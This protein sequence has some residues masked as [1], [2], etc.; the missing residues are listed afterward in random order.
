MSHFRTHLLFISLVVLW[1][2]GG[3]FGPKL[4]GLAN[5][6]SHQE[7]DEIQNSPPN[8]E[9]SQLPSQQPPEFP[10][11]STPEEEVDPALSCAQTLSVGANISSAIS[12]AANG[13]VICLS[14]GNYGPIQLANINRSGFVTITSE[15]S[16]LAEMSPDIYNS[17]YIKFVRLKLSNA[18]IRA[19]SVS[20]HFI[21]NTF[22]PETPH[23]LFNN[24]VT[25]PPETKMDYLVD[26]NSFDRGQNILF[27]GRLSLRGVDGAVISNNLFSNVPTKN[28][29]DG[30]Q[31]I[32]GSRNLMIGP[33]N[34]F[35]GIQ[36]SQ[37]GA[38]HCDAIQDYG[39]GPNNKIIGNFFKDGDTFIMMPDGSNNY[40]V[41]DN[42]F[43][44]TGNSYPDKIQFGS[45]AN[46]IFRHNTVL[47]VRVSFDS[48]TNNPAST[49]AVG[50]NNIMI[51]GSSFK[52]S[53][54]SGCSNCTF[55]NNLTISPIFIGGTNPKTWNG[56]QLAPESPGYQSAT[57]GN[58]MGT[59][60]YGP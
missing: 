28:A 49:N 14:P 41:S 34:I 7:N 33:G 57:D 53:N 25:C 30:I 51:L 19:C 59:T 52:T 4:D 8:S 23:L 43:D 15:N 35:T 9:T 42:I 46:P 6:S 56:F 38:V 39:G 29:S 45:A 48:K 27:E 5:R 10:V 17:K 20:I 44:G 24:D 47:S 22:I 1:G 50:E 3:S 40:L 60:Y 55:N 18:S 37:C 2:C 36:E 58:D 11:P 21:K 54:G 12:S 31:I 13:S 26:G 16:T 32:G